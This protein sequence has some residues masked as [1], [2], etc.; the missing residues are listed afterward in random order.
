MLNLLLY[1]TAGILFLIFVYSFYIS[2]REKENRASFKFI[3]LVLGFPLPLLL[4]GFYEV[5][6]SLILMLLF[7]MDNFV[8][9][10]KPKTL[11][12]NGSEQ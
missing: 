12:V 3:I 8:Y 7:G 9:G 10:R 2:V 11:R 5:P 1:I 4:A 6:A